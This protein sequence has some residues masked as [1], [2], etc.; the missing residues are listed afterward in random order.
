MV[1]SMAAGAGGPISSPIDDLAPRRWGSPTPPVPKSV[2]GPEA[3]MS[4]VRFAALAAATV[5]ALL[6]AVPAQ[7][8]TMTQCSALYKSAQTAG[9][10]NGMNWNAFRKANCGAT[11]AAATTTTP[12]KPAVVADASAEPN[13]ANTENAPEP[14]VSKIVP[15]KGV[16]FPKSISSKYAS[17][18][19]G[20]A[21]MHTCLDQY[22]L[23]KTNNDLSGL[24]WIA[25][26]GGYYSICNT[27]LKG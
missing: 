26:G 15:P 25:K 3:I 10:L 12:V 4:P 9:T 23:D 1:A 2:L 17:E 7:A 19:P 6:C 13:A 21:R 5:F 22:K 14:S 24:T 8:V 27:Q 20:K 11:N 16:I 18:T